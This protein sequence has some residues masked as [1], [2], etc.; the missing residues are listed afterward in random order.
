MRYKKVEVAHIEERIVDN[1]EF[2][3]GCTKRINTLRCWTQDEITIG[4]RLGKVYPEG[5]QRRAYDLDVCAECFL[6]KVVP[7]LAAVGL[8]F[9]Q[10]DVDDDERVLGAPTQT[11]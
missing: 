1:G 11:T 4:A 3:D 7:A 10:R 9:R 5:D 8:T 2:C 6:E